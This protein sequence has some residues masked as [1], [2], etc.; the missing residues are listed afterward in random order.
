MI[1]RI[2]FVLFIVFNC[3]DALEVKISPVKTKF[4]KGDKVTVVMQYK[5]TDPIPVLIN[6]WFL[7]KKE[8]DEPIFEVSCN[9]AHVNYMGKIVKRGAL[10]RK[11]AVSI[12][13][14][15]TAKSTIDVSSVYNMSESCNYKIELADDLETLLFNGSSSFRSNTKSET[16]LTLVT[17]PATMF[18]EGRL[19][20]FTRRNTRNNRVTRSNGITYNQCS[21]IQS[22]IAA[23]SV[24]MAQSYLSASLAYL[25]NTKPSET[26][27][28]RTW[29]GQYSP[30]NWE[31]TR[32]RYA[33]MS[34]TLS[35]RNVLVDCSCEEDYFAYVYPSDP[36][37]IYVCQLFWTAP[38]LGTDSK[39]GTI[40][41]EISHFYQTIRTTD[42]A[43]GQTSS[44]NLARR[45][46]TKAMNNAD[47]HEYFAE[48]TPTLP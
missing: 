37:D 21:S 23:I 16:R 13:A 9:G 44:I 18:V 1:S 28:F 3:F 35:S 32:A 11:D 34:V 14:G 15:Q 29:F 45:S 43:S 38:M 42:L 48:N 17:N 2:L 24:N 20:S 4:S 39:A 26:Q 30:D 22:I 40:V 46:S 33:N 27:R 10:Q 6:P 36:F 12:P 41:H 5:N 25:N 8:L 19:N 7:P 31:L 47:S